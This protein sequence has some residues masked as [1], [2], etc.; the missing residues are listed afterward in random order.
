MYYLEKMKENAYGKHGFGN[1]MCS[2]QTKTDVQ[3]DINQSVES[4]EVVKGAV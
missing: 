2:N 1:K 3:Y 4:T